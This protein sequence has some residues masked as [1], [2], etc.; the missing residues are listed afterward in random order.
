MTNDPQPLINGLTRSETDASA[1]VAGVSAAL[2]DL[3]DLVSEAISLTESAAHPLNGGMR[4]QAAQ[5]RTEAFSAIHDA[6]S[7]IASLTAQRD[8][9]AGA[10]EH[11]F[12]L[13]V[14]ELTERNAVLAE[15]TRLTAD[16]AEAR[17]KVEHLKKLIREANAANLRSEYLPPLKAPASAPIKI[18]EVPIHPKHGPLW[19]DT[20]E[21]GS[22]LHR[23]ARYPLM[24]LYAD[25]PLGAL[26]ARQPLTDEE[27]DE[28]WNVAGCTGYGRLASRYQV[29]EFYR[30]ATAS[31]IPRDDAKAVDGEA[32]RG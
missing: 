27:I 11:H 23:S 28:L 20:R 25:S 30:L 5:A 24:N 13:R 1:S 9:R 3:H 14:S 21:A 15:V 2:V 29:H 16:L 6:Q 8:E 26:P 10:A 12:S 19:S 7:R 22:D 32:D 18:A 31:A 17:A 4:R